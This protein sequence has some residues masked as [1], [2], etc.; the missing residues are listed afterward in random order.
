MEDKDDDLFSF[1]YEAKSG[2]ELRDEG[3][4]RV[5]AASGSWMSRAVQCASRSLPHDFVGTGEDVRRV[6]TREIGPPHSPNAWGALTNVLS[7]PN[8]GILIDTG[9]VRKMKAPK[10]H[11]RRTPVYRMR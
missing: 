9:K 7:K 1:Y 8:T 2:E 10:S 5:T 4:A 6:V 11:G 3:L